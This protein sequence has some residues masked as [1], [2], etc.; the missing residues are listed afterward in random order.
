MGSIDWREYIKEHF[1][2]IL[3]WGF[4][5]MNLFSL[6]RWQTLL[7][8]GLTSL[9]IFSLSLSL[10][11]CGTQD[12]SEPDIPPVSR[13][14]EPIQSVTEVSPPASLQA[15]HRTLDQYQPEVTIITPQPDELLQDNS[16]TVELNV[17]NFPIFQDETFGLGPHLQVILDNQLTQ[18]VY[19]L[20]QPLIFEN[21]K[22]G[23]HTLRVFAAYPW[24][25]SFKNEMAY[26]Q[27]TFHLFTKTPNN[28]PDASQ[29]LLTLNRPQGTYGAEP[30]LLDF[31][32]S[33]RP[34]DP[35]SLEDD[36][37]NGAN[38]QVE[39]IL[40]GERYV[41]DQWQP[42]YIE[43]VQVGKNW[44]QLQY[45]NQQG[46]PVDNV[47]NNI[48]RAFT[49]DPDLT[50]SLSQ[51]FNG[52]FSP[53]QL[54]GM[55]DPDYVP[56]VEEP[57]GLIEPPVS[58][59]EDGAESDPLPLLEDTPEATIETPEDVEVF[60]DTIEP[61]EIEETVEAVEA[62]SDII[63]PEETE[64]VEELE[65]SSD[66]IEPELIETPEELEVSEEIVEPEAIETPAV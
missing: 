47:Y 9:I 52:E 18:P 38:W 35:E 33:N 12:L 53:A 6:N 43:G 19:D 48:A 13:R 29:P 55:V 60:S 45:L 34:I 11:G 27:T 14:S 57:E 50:D 24:D 63:E 26:A 61:E 31:Y 5:S 32:L 39:I 37:D 49:Y 16:V 20:E 1:S 62:P 25:E 54:Q 21:L 65:A 42:I 44:I 7:S 30:I 23:T 17:E 36:I 64:T 51:V 3:D 41:I 59:E 4:S 22:A 58:E 15:L 66:T 2:A 46:E 8:K 56:V 40:N 28:N 10:A